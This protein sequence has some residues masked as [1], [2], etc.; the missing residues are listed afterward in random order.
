LN[1]LLPLPLPLLWTFCPT[2]YSSVIPVFVVLWLRRCRCRW[3][4]PRSSLRCSDQ[5]HR[6]A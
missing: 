6:S 3:V 2:L 5:T 1:M 4:I